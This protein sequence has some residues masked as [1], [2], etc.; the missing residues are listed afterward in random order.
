MK[1]LKT[2]G[3]GTLCLFASVGAYATYE[4]ITTDP[5]VLYQRQLTILERTANDTKEDIKLVRINLETLEAR[6]KRDQADWK[7]TRCLMAR[8]EDERGIEVND[9]TRELCDFTK[10]VNQP[11]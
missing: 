11:R 7:D 5:V 2:F 1:K 9:E 3:I 10:V 8:E 4:K 6:L